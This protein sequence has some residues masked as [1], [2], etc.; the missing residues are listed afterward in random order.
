MPFLAL[1]LAFLSFLTAIG[2]G[3]FGFFTKNSMQKMAGGD[4]RRSPFKY[5]KKL[6][7]DRLSKSAVLPFILNVYFSR[8]GGFLTRNCI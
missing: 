1:T 3:R 6:D 8:G 7:E 4:G 2:A 5:L